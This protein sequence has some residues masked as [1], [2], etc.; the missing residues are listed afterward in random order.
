MID[1]F[2]AVHEALRLD[3]GPQWKKRIITKQPPGVGKAFPALVPQVDKDGNIASLGDF[4]HLAS[5]RVTTSSVRGSSKGRAMQP[6][7]ACR[8]ES[9]L[10]DV[11]APDTSYTWFNDE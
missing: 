6:R 7:A 9:I 4:S 2:V 11:A 3:F 8:I 5:S 1:G 10:P